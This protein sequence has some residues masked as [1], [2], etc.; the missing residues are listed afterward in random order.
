[1]EMTREQWAGTL[2]NRAMRLVRLSQAGAP[3]ALLCNEAAL[4]VK[5]ARKLD[6]QACDV[7]LSSAGYIR[8][9]VS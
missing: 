3:A 6:T 2:A 8:R 5:A 1:M 9:E 7:A 4:I